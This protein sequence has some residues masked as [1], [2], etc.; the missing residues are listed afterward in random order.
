M[1]ECTPR[2]TD[3]WPDSPA[4]HA[5][6]DRFP[7][8]IRSRTLDPGAT[9]VPRAQRVGGCP[10][11]E[12]IDP[13]SLLAPPVTHH[14]RPRRSCPQ[15]SIH[16]A[17]RGTRAPG[18]RTARARAGRGCVAR[19]RAR[20]GPRCGLRRLARR[21]HRL[22]QRSRRGGPRASSRRHHT[23]TSGRAWPDRVHAFR[24]TPIAHTGDAG[25]LPRSGGRGRHQPRSARR[26]RRREM[27]PHASAG[28]G[29]RPAR[30]RAGRTRPSRESSDAPR[31]RSRSTS[32]PCLAKSGC[33]GRCEL[34]FRFWSEAV[35]TVGMEA[36]EIRPAPPPERSA[37]GLTS[38][39]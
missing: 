26:R 37:Q 10:P 36:A 27:P 19:R 23:R 3:G 34:V 16:H 24:I 4:F 22:R 32:R 12:S 31:P 20:R 5:G 29:P 28:A 17:R 25:P 15:K 8:A 21:R 11:P 13:G 30:P 2:A 9:T 7:F 18:L 1:E 33:E 6:N 14:D 35:G 39:T 38:R